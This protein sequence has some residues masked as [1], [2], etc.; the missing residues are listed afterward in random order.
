MEKLIIGAQKMGSEKNTL[1]IKAGIWYT[2]CNFLVRAISFISMPIFTRL[3]SLEEYGNYNNFTSWLNIIMVVTTMDLHATIN[4]A[5]FDFEKEINDYLSTITVTSL[6]IPSGIYLIAICFHDIFQK[7][8]D[9]DI[10]SIHC[11][12]LSIIFSSAIN[13]FQAKQR[14]NYKYRESVLITFISTFITVGFS[15]A[16]VYCMNNKYYGR[17]IGQ[18]IPATLFNA[19]IAIYLITCGKKLKWKYV[20]YAIWICLPYVP[21]LLSM[22]ILSQYDRIQIKNYCGSEDVAL[23]SLAY[24][25]ALVMNIFLNSLNNAWSPWMGDMIHENN[26]VA[27]RKD[28]K[29]YI[30]MFLFLTIGALLIAPELLLFFGGSKYSEALMVMPP[31]IAGVFFQFIYTLYVNIE[32]YEKK[33]WG[34]AFATGIAAV[35]N[36]ILNSIFIPKYGYIAAA[37]TTLFCYGVLCMLHYFLVKRIKLDSAYNTFFIIG[38][39][40]SI[41]MIS[42]SMY[43]I[44]KI[45]I[46]RLLLV[47]IYISVFGGLLF[48]NKKIIRSFLGKK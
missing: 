3:M 10:I 22:N 32:M 40:L 17:V 47:I 26:I 15:L 36:I 27:I 6:V 16:L 39:L 14:V 30:L 41:L 21:H 12:F 33:V 31:V 25:C 7:V 35:L 37:F 34:V 20:K 29:K 28:S 43:F 8:L 46:I 19:A 13:I 44:Y 42:L 2:I 48:K 23:Y 9:M 5:R 24:S 18:T 4:R 11:M 38:I 45:V 1:A